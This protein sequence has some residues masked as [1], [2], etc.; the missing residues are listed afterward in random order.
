[1]RTWLRGRMGRDGDKQAMEKRQNLAAFWALGLLNNVVYV[2][3]LAGAKEINAGGVGLVFLADV[4]PTFLVKLSAPYWFH[5]VSYSLR[6]SLCGFLMAASLLTVALGRTLAVQLT[7]VGFCSLQAGIG[8]AS[9]L[10]LTAQ[11]HGPSTITAWSSGT[12]FAGILGYAWVVFFHLL[13]HMSFPATLIAALL[14]PIAWMFTFFYALGDPTSEAYQEVLAD[15]NDELSSAVDERDEEEYG[16]DEGEDG[17]GAGLPDFGEGTAASALL[18]PNAISPLYSYPS[19]SLR[20]EAE[21]EEEEGR[22]GEREGEGRGRERK[23][24]RVQKRARTRK[25]KRSHPHT[26]VFTIRERWSLFLSLWPYT[27]PLVTVYWAEYAMQSGAWSAIGFPVEEEKARKLFYAWANMSYQ[28]GVFLSRSSGLLLPPSLPLLWTLPALQCLLLLFF[29]LNAIWH[30][31]YD[32][33]LLSL[34]FVAGLFGGAVYVA[35][36]SLISR[37]TR[38]DHRELALVSASIADT[39]GIMLSNV[40]GLLLQVISIDEKGRE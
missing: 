31:W 19:T 13:L 35:G 25:G 4:A 5:H 36:F 12:G 39:V 26:H 2:I 20:N 11:Y 6:A 33:G 18:S 14:L 1:M 15:I 8:E 17:E 9:M 10:G 22:G 23:G 21:G 3:M 40:A 29:C 37:H 16:V 38:D 24:G 32:W 7:G 27:V 30:F 34:C 28:I